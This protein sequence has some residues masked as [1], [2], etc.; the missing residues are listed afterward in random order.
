MGSTNLTEFFLNVEK[1]LAYIVNALLVRITAIVIQTYIVSSM[2][3]TDKTGVCSFV[4][5]K[6]KGSV[7]LNLISTIF[8]KFS[9]NRLLEQIKAEQYKPF[10]KL[11]Y[12]V[13]A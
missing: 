1:S 11:R 5:F 12:L 3:E 6:M 2:S 8:N 7:L 9:E 10:L 13:S 4:K